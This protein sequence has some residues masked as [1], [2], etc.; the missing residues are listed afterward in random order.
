MI[1][2]LHFLKQRD[3]SASEFHLDDSISGRHRITIIQLLL[4]SLIYP[5][6]KQASYQQKM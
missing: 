1:G 2:T 5:K 3:N 4:V 6:I